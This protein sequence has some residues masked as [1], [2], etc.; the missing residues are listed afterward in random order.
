MKQLIKKF[1]LI[2]FLAQKN[3]FLFY[4][5]IEFKKNEFNDKDFPKKLIRRNSL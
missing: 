4:R 3:Y 1:S 5:I 2:N